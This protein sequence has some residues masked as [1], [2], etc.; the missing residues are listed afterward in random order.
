M[1]KNIIHIE[2]SCPAKWE[3]MKP[4][5]NGRYCSSCQKIVVDFSRKWLDEIKEYFSAHQSVCGNYQERH[6]NTSNTWYNFLNNIENKLSSIRFRHLSLLLVTLFLFLTSCIAPRRT[7][8]HK[9]PVSLNKNSR[10][11][12]RLR[13]HLL[14][15]KTAINK[16]YI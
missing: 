4:I 12:I 15:T 9:M 1:G 16:G 11:R 2:N 13:F 5:D 14:S 3:G 7:R 8:G 6:T 10:D